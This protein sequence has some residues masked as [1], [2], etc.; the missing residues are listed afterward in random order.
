[1]KYTAEQLE[2]MRKFL[3]QRDFEL[4][5]DEGIYSILQDGCRGW[6]NIPDEE[7]IEEYNNCQDCE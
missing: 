6:N 2:D 5:D 4:L 1:M 3:T 7:V